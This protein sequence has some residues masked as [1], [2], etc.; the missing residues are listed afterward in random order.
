M[1]FTNPSILE[2]ALIALSQ[3]ETISQAEASLKPFLK[4]PA[5]I[6]L[7]LQQLQGSG[8]DSVR[9][10]AA[11][12]LKRNISKLF[13]KCGPDDQLG[14]KSTVLSV[15][16]TEATTT[17]RNALCGTIAQLAK[18][19][20]KVK[21]HSQ[22]EWNELF[23]LLTQ[24]LSSPGEEQKVLCFSLLDQ[25]CEEIPDFLKLNIL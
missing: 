10:H 1:D 17:V 16:L 19:V 5:C 2:Q 4:S 9:L 3:P 20:F 25:L 18:K 6:P 7:L 11:F 12:L 13:S 14:L 8:N 22:R 24:L 21:D 15:L 23:T